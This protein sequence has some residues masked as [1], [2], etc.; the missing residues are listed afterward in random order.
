MNTKM[1]FVSFTALLFRIRDKQ[2]T[3]EDLSQ[4]LFFFG[5]S[6]RHAFEPWTQ[7]HTNE[8]EWVTKHGDEQARVHRMLV[9][10][11]EAAE[12]DGRAVW[13]TRDSFEQDDK[14]VLTEMLSANGFDVDLSD[15]GYL[16]YPGVADAVRKSGQPLNVIH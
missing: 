13:R 16:N 14:E 12:K 2:V 11:I 4:G 7:G 8:L 1:L 10:A 15:L 9:T 6:R 5:C 3:E